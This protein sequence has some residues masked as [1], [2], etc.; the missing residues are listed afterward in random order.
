MT[1]ITIIIISIIAITTA[2]VTVIDIIVDTIITRIIIDIIIGII[3]VDGPVLI[4]RG[5]RGGEREGSSESG[6]LDR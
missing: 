2:P 5:Q 1:T 4:R 6:C 3:L